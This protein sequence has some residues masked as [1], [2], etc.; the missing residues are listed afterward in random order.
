MS[1]TRRLAVRTLAYDY[2]SGHFV[3]PH[4][5]DE[6]QL[7]YAT[8]GVM[9][10]TTPAGT[11]VV[12]AHRGAWIPGSVTHSIRMSGPVSMRT[13]YLL[14][15]LAGSL[16]DACYVLSVSPLLR[17]LVLH[18][19]SQGGLDRRVPA[20][21]HVIA[22]LLDQLALL[23]AP[24]PA[25]SLRQPRDPRAVRVARRLLEAP[26]DRRP[27][28][29][30]LAGVGASQRTIER[31][32]RAETGLSFGRWRQQLRL[33]EALRL[34]AAGEPVTSVALDVG[35]DSLSAFVSVFHRTFGTTPGRYFR[36]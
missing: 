14:P 9:T 30:L 18:A 31:L 1:Q 12:P 32:F 26:G 23:P 25:S 24:A 36:S 6:H 3:R 20:D 34:L 5:H 16:P 10:V 19:V 13:L 29:A 7:V 4:A 8:Q 27:V 17:E 2:P 11:W 33:T 28:A 15:S 35:Y 21:A 22:V